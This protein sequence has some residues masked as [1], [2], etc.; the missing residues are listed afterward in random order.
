MIIADTI[1]E[2]IN[3]LDFSTNVITHT[4]DG[5][6]TTLNVFDTFHVRPR[7]II[8]VDGTGYKV[9][10]VN[11]STKTIIVQGVIVSPVK[12][13]VPT[14]FFFHGT[15]KAVNHQL[16]GLSDSQKVPM[17]YLY[18]VIE[19]ELP[20]V[21][22]LYYST[23]SLWLHFLDVDNREDWNTD[24]RYS[25]IIEPQII[26]TD[27]FISKLNT[28]SKF[29]GDERSKINRKTFPIWG[30]YVNYKGA[31]NSIFNEYLGGV[32]LRFSLPFYKD[33]NC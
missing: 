10:S 16:S 22:S 30:E 9:L 6:N 25:N 3:S 23:P 1:E 4:N 7:L 20:E 5:T 31:E 8:D 15:P 12:V 27:Y 32:S 26:L 29:D 17:I 14:P 13:T 33:C 21:G 28:F 2:Y 24:D 19:E 11:Y 18:E